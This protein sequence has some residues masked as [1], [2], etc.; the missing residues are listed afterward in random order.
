MQKLPKSQ[1]KE[2]PEMS[3]RFMTMLA[4]ESPNFAEG[5][6]VIAALKSFAPNVP[7]EALGLQETETGSPTHLVK[8][9]QTVLA[10]MYVDQPL[11]ADAIDR[12]LAY[13]QTW[14]GA[15]AEMQKHSAHVIAAVFKSDESFGGQ[16]QSAVDLTLLT[17][18]LIKS[19]PVLSVI[20]TAGNTISAPSVVFEALKQISEQSFPLDLWLQVY[21]YRPPSIPETEKVIGFVTEGL[22]PFVGREIQFEPAPMP[23]QDVA[24]RVLNIALY[25]LS[26]GPVLKDGETL[27]MS[28]E[29]KIHIRHMPEGAQP[30]VPILQLMLGRLD[31]ER[32][33]SSANDHRSTSF[34]KRGRA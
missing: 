2:E 3:D 16:R 5:R 29:E 15:K 10:I 1:R 25:L 26:H 28:E 34:G 13:N 8:I 17:A 22:L 21:P 14:P 6:E 19:H 18:A 31:R 33:E 20:W 32:G 4:L 11:P 24:S 27:G 12:P 9:G 23:P 7:A 30:G